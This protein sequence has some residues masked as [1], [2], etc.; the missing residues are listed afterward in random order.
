MAKK[1]TES[2]TDAEVA[3]II[4]LAESGFGVFPGNVLVDVTYDTTGSIELTLDGEIDEEELISALQNS[5]AD[6]LNIHASDVEV[7]IDPDSGV[8]TYTISSSS[9]DEAAALQ[10]SMGEDLTQ[11]AITSALSTAVPE[12]TGVID[13]IFFDKRLHYFLIIFELSPQ[14][15]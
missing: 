3:D 7:S 2:L 4:T 1:V 14:M 15:N 12:V 6:S 5:I 9:Y 11:D 13:T 8:A 10:A